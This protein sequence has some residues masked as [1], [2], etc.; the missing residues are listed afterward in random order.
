MKKVYFL[1][2]VILICVLLN[3][4]SSSNSISQTI[5]VSENV[6][7]PDEVQAWDKLVNV[8][9]MLSN[10]SSLP[11]IT[12][13]GVDTFYTAGDLV[14]VYASLLLYGTPVNASSYCNLTITHWNGTDMVTDLNDASMVYNGTG[15]YYYNYNIPVS[16]TSVTY[17]VLVEADPGGAKT[18]A[19]AGF[20]VTDFNITATANLSEVTDLVKSINKT[21]T[22][23]NETRWGNFS[24]TQP[25]PTIL[26]FQA[27]IK[28]LN[29][30]PLP[31]G[32]IR[33]NI[34]DYLQPSVPWVNVYNNT[35]S[36]G[37]FN[38]FLGTEYSLSLIP[39]RIYQRDLTI[40]DEAVFNLSS[41]NY[42]TFT[43]Y[44]VA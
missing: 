34:T 37:E 8:E 44:I 41:C 36:N 18:Q 28:D 25:V 33:V 7:S 9:D 2:G 39:K 14:T 16:P 4:V 3:L 23:L 5:N 11:S 29:G 13:G 32:S 43:T 30:N 21:V 12:I 10:L 6:S 15:V 40:C 19:A 38:L 31:Q 22:Y 1:L 26:K 35:I 20:P 17:G 24:Y 42:E 27:R